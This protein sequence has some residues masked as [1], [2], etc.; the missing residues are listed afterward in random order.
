MGLS[1]FPSERRQLTAQPLMVPYCLA[2]DKATVEDKRAER[3]KLYR[4]RSFGAVRRSLERAYEP[5]LEAT[6]DPQMDTLL[7][8]LMNTSHHEMGAC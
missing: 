4:H 5:A 6:A 2:G 7:E 3:S 8:Q 1:S